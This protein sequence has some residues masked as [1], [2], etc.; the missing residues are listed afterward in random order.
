MIIHDV[1]QADGLS[2]LNLVDDELD[3]TIGDIG[4]SFQ[5]SL[6]FH[7][8]LQKKKKVSI[9]YPFSADKMQSISL[10]FVIS[11]RWVF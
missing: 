9:D 4:F 1:F 2:S 11:S 7:K 10:S 8:G 6:C 5:P 3:E